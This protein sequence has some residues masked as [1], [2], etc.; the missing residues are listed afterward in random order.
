LAISSLKRDVIASPGFVPFDLVLRLDALAG[1]GIDVLAVN[2]MSGLAVQDVK[3][4]AISRGRGC[5]ERD[6]ARHSPI[7][8]TPFQFARAAMV[9]SLSIRMYVCSTAAGV[10]DVPYG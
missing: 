5:E 2:A 1:F 3:G 4:D 10:R 7:L 6:R 8:R 9:R